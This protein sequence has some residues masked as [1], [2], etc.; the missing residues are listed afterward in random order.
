MTS[1]CRNKSAITP[2]WFKSLDTNSNLTP[3]LHM[4]FHLILTVLWQTPVILW[5]LPL[6]Q[7][8]EIDFYIIEYRISSCSFCP[9]IVSSLDY[10]LQ[11][12]LLWPLALCTDY[13]HPNEGMNQRYLKNWANVA[14]SMLRP[15]LKIWDWDWV[16]GHA[17][18]TISSLGVRSPWLHIIYC[19]TPP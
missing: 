6:S 16:F 14:D 3:I 12:Y 19:C 9:W 7:I 13:R 5:G 2:K 11:L 18:K 8:Q 10:L 4:A 15:Y 1:I 17:V